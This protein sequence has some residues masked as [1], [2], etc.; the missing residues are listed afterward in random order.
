MIEVAPNI[1]RLGLLPFNLINAYIAG[2]ILFDACTRF[3]S[4]YFLRRL[5]GVT[6]R[7]VALTHVHPD[8]QGAANA[9]CDAFRCP[10]ACHEADAPA[11]E[12]RVDMGPPSRWIHAASNWMAGPRRQVD[13]TLREGDEI[14]GFRVIETPGHTPGHVIFFRDADR[15]AIAGD[16]VTSMNLL[17]LRPGLHE[18]PAIF[19]EDARLNRRSIQ[20]LADLGPSTVL[21]GHGPPLRDPHA[22]HEFAE[23]LDESC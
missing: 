23:R 13:R 21:F 22:L 4:R 8:H 15:V 14:A 10:L 3:E 2:D 1:R 9:V 17:T 7:A 16:L 5:K 19:C 18:P 6:L 12:G 11:M 20:K